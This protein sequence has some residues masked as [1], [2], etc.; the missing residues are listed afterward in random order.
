MT[1]EFELSDE[2]LAEV[3]GAGSHFHASQFA[4]NFGNQAN[5]VNSSTNALLVGGGKKSTNELAVQGS[6]NTIG[7]SFTGVNVNTIS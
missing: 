5:F 3:S 4:T 7:N 6:T 2:Q 1:D